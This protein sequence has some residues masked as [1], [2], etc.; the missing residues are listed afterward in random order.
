MNDKQP[1]DEQPAAALCIIRA[2]R[3]STRQP[4]FTV[5]VVR[6]VGSALPPQATMTVQ[7]GKVVQLV[8]E[9]LREL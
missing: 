7:P 2:E 6:D 3:D 8:E 9:F 4:V 5:S 1:A